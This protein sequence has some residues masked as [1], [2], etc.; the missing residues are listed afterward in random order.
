MSPGRRV[1]RPRGSRTAQVAPRPP[2][3][4]R[5]RGERGSP[6]GFVLTLVNGSGI[7]L[8]KQTRW[9]LG[10]RRAGDRERRRKA[11]LSGDAP[12]RSSLASRRGGCGCG[13]KPEAGTGARGSRPQGRGGL[14]R[15]RGRAE[16]TER[17]LSR[18]PAPLAPRGLPEPHARVLQARPLRPQ[19][20]RDTLPLP[21]LPPLLRGATAAGCR[22]HIHTYTH[23]H[24][25]GGGSSPLLAGYPEAR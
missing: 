5:A 17:P 1:G 12:P 19:P 3:A 16:A 22:Q 10:T 20:S 13:P 11:S 24:N 7:Q 4:W 9:G 21:A 8:G 18:P 14:G 15:Q 6:R 2:R 23:T 25:G